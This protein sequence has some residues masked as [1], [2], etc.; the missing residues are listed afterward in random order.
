MVAAPA[1]TTPPT[2]AAWARLV[3]KRARVRHEESFTLG[4]S[5]VRLVIVFMIFL[6]RI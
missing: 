6:F 5:I 2:G 4:L 3:M 1:A